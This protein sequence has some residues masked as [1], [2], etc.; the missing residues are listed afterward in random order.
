MTDAAALT[1]RI[2]RSAGGVV[3]RVNGEG[4]PLFVIPGMEGGGE[5]CMQLVHV[6]VN[7][8]Q[9]LNHG[10]RVVLVD[11][12]AEMCPS[13]EALVDQIYALLTQEGIHNCQIWAQSFG[14][15]LAVRLAAH[16]D[17][18]IDRFL[19]VSA[20]TSLPKPSACIGAALTAVS[21]RVLYKACIGPI[22][23]YVFD[24]VGDQVGHP[25]FGAM[26]QADPR[27]IAR[28]TRWLCNRD[29]FEEFASNYTPTKVFLGTKDRLLNLR[30]Q[31]GIFADLART[32]ENYHFSLI[33]GSGHVTLPTPVVFEAS[34]QFL[35][36]LMMKQ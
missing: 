11:Y 28:R 22:A 6:V 24:P 17:L 4:D 16:S 35:E 7:K 14:N 3:L 19:L 13:L 31:T 29:F 36:W 34:Q 23:R 25:F 15:L 9:A 10:Y 26:Q 27:V 12:S 21:P 20:F 33:E 5:S 32:R 2:S 18:N 8:A 1:W 30:Q